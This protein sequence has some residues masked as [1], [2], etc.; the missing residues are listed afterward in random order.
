MVT[1]GNLS[2]YFGSRELF[3]KISFFIGPRDRI[4]L[5]GKNGAGKSTLLKTLAGI[6]NPNEGSISLTRGSTVGYLPQEMH[7]N[8]EATVYEE[9]SKAF[10]EVQRLRDRLEGL[11]PAAC[12]LKKQHL[13]LTE[14]Y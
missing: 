2:I 13:A 4:G 6:Q 11:V 12:A 14:K 8:E 9:A 1:V 3:S 5:V 7:H 10:A